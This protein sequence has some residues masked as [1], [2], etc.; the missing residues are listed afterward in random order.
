M[1]EPHGR[2]PT[3]YI[4]FCQRQHCIGIILRGIFWD[5]ILISTACSHSPIG[6]P[7]QSFMAEKEALLLSAC[8]ETVFAWSRKPSTLRCRCTVCDLI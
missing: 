8:V 3:L 2:L 4:L 6:L 5:Q 1:S 7:L